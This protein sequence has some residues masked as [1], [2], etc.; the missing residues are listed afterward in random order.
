M[1]YKDWLYCAS[2]TVEGSNF[3]VRARIVYIHTMKEPS[4][5]LSNNVGMEKT[6]QTPDVNSN[7]QRRQ[8]ASNGSSGRLHISKLQL[9]NKQ[10]SGK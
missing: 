10:H 7:R 5:E 3:K 2:V 9:I 6:W 8:C 4:T 1:A